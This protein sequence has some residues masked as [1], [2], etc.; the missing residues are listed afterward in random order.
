MGIPTE[1][2]RIPQETD[3]E[4]REVLCYVKVAGMV[5]FVK[6]AIYSTYYILERSN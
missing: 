3:V 2:H 5:K 6:T 4:Y 1:S